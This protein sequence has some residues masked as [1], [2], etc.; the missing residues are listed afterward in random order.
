MFQD[1]SRS[2]SLCGRSP[3]P[4]SPALEQVADLVTRYPNLSEIEL[5][6][7]INLY[8]ELSA[9]EMALM[10]S[11]SELAPKLD[12]FYK[13]QRLRLRRPFREYAVLLA[14][15]LAGMVVAIWGGTRVVM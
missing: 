8:R 13:E 12:G 4:E 14:I 6:R 10:I 5:A 7:L 9:L 1:F 3:A 2:N 11:D 15:A